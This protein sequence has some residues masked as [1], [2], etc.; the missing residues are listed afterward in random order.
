MYYI[1]NRHPEKSD[2]E[3]LKTL[4]S[5]RGELARPDHP[6]LPMRD[7]IFRNPYAEPVL[8]KVTS[9]SRGCAI[10]AVAN[11]Y[12]EGGEVRGDVSIEDLPYRVE[13]DE[14]AYYMFFSRGRG[15]VGRGDRIE[16]SLGELGVEVITICPIRGGK[17]VIGLENYLIPPS[18]V[19]LVEARQKIL[20]IPRAP[21]K[22]LYYHQGRFL[23]HDVVPGEAVEV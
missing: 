20:A 16:I 14:A 22:L 9:R 18:M 13:W 10:V 2:V 19:D 8:L 5:P 15:T 7:L 4:V 6:E 1:R 21:G 11:I 12:R 23:E 3:L 17:A